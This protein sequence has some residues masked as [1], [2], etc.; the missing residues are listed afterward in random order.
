MELNQLSS[1]IIKAAINVHNEL[2]PGLSGGL[3]I[4]PDFS[5]SKNQ[6]NLK[7]ISK[8]SVGSSDRRE[9]ARELLTSRNY[10]D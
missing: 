1:Q 8:I 9:R 3:M 4:W 10:N 5:L 6:A 7:I 2:G